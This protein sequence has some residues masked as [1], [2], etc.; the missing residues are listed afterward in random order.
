M[1]GEGGGVRA[2]FVGLDQGGYRY[3]SANA[4]ADPAQASGPSARYQPRCGSGADAAIGRDEQQPQPD[5]PRPE[6]VPAD[7]FTGA[8]GRSAGP[9]SQYRGAGRAPAAP[10]AA[11]P[12][13]EPQGGDRCTLNSLL[14]ARGAVPAPRPT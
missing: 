14:T 2:Q 4:P 12:Q 6:R 7:R 5:R 8:R 3:Q 1:A 13:A 11:A 9:A 10:V